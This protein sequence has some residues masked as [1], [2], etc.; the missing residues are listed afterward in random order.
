M[1]VFISKK[2]CTFGAEG[3]TSANDTVKIKR[4]FIGKICVPVDQIIQSLFPGGQFVRLV[5]GG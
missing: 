2:S 3:I 4:E 5:M 1:F